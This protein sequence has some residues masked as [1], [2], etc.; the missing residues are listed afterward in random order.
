MEN[1]E[2]KLSM[3]DSIRERLSIMIADFMDGQE[4]EIDQAIG[5]F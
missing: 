4:T 3:L 1:A 2:V 5:G